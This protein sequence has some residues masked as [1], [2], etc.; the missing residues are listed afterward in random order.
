MPVRPTFARSRV[1]SLGYAFTI[2]AMVEMYEGTDY[3]FPAPASTYYL[4]D[5]QTGSKKQLFNAPAGRDLF[6]Y[7]G[8]DST[9]SSDGKSLILGNVFLPLD[10]PNAEENGEREKH[11]YVA[12]YR[13]DSGKLSGI[14]PVV[15]GE[16]PGRYFLSEGFFQDEHTVVLKFAR[17]QMQSPLYIGPSVAVFRE[18]ADGSWKKASQSDDDPRLSKLPVKIEEKEAINLRFIFLLKSKSKLSSVFCGSR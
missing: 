11:P 16:R 3:K 17:K 2:S 14:I 13:L 9:W 7:S 6:W 18:D 4:F 5:L 15:S 1:P 12:V 8:L 10:S